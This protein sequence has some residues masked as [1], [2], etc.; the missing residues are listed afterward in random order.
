MKWEIHSFPVAAVQQT[1]TNLITENIRNLFSYSS[2][3]SVSMAVL[4]EA[5]GKDVLLASSSPGATSLQSLPCGHITFSFACWQ[6]FLCF[7][8][9]RT[10]VIIFRYAYLVL[11]VTQR[12]NLK[13]SHMIREIIFYSI[14][15][16]S[17]YLVSL[18]FLSELVKGAFQKNKKQIW[19]TF[20]IQPLF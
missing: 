4:P 20:Y 12:I 6:I 3:Q 7:P 8:L 15:S 19:S 17:N 2:S 11:H 16:I 10:H 5:L 13:Y 9:I 1:T 18:N 14:V